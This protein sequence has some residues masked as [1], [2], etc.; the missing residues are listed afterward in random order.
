MQTR[1][2]PPA[3]RG[4]IRSR[5]YRVVFESDTY[6][7]RVFDI[8][9]LILICLSVLVVMLDSLAGVRRTYYE[10]LTF[11]EWTLTIMFTVEYVLRVYSV[12]NRRRYIFSFFGII[13]FL[14]ILPTYLALFIG[15]VQ[16]LMVVRVLR[17]LRIFRIFKLTRY[18]SEAD[19]LMQALRASRAKITVFLGT[20]LTLVVVIGAL[21]YLV[22]GPTNGFSSI[23]RS[24]YWAIV[25]LTTVGYGDIAPQTPLGQLIACIVMILGYG[26]IAVPTGIVSVE[27]QAAT[28]R[29]LQSRACPH[30]GNM[31]H[32]MDAR[33][34]KIC[35]SSLSELSE[36]QS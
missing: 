3:R 24:I 27:L 23:P 34:C 19:V 6:A 28:K 5:L 20:V 22:E 11:I 12:D 32:D 25:T 18:L 35:G 31:R 26:I 15:G 16:Y 29:S 9:L 2:A 14:S 13:D 30:C 8:C 36:T 21:M 17:L 33:F 7:G 10:Q 4:S 1:N